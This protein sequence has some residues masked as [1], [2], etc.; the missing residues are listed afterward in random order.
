VNEQQ[1]EQALAAIL[2]LLDPYDAVHDR[3]GVIG[4]VD[5]VRVVRQAHAAVFGSSGR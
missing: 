5:D 4:Y 2:Y 1:R 3:H